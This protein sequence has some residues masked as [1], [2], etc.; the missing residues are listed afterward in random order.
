MGKYLHTF[1]TFIAALFLHDNDDYWDTK[2][3]IRDKT[4]LIRFV[5]QRKTA[6]LLLGKV[7]SM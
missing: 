3:K 2:I 1:Y 6:F 5:H 4:L 7:P